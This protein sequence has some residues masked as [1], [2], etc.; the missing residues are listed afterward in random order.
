VRAQ[1]I[2][3]KR[4]TPATAD[5][6]AFEAGRI[7]EHLHMATEMDHGPVSGLWHAQREYMALLV[8]AVLA[9]GQDVLR[10]P[11]QPPLG[12]LLNVWRPCMRAV[13]PC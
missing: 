5:L 13:I 2:K 6:I 12:M 7:T 10:R 9:A 4:W 1:D 3:A 11:V 8:D